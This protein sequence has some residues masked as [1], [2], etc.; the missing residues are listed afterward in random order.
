MKIILKLLI[1]L[2]LFTEIGVASEI[3]VFEFTEAELSQLEVRKVRGAD[4]KT[5]YSVGSNE[6]GNF[7]KSVADNSQLLK[8][9]QDARLPLLIAT[10]QIAG[11]I[12]PGKDGSF[13][14]IDNSGYVIPKP[15]MENLV[16]EFVDRARKAGIA[17]IGE[18][19]ITLDD[20]N[21]NFNKWNF[22]RF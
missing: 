19:A 4:N 6:N 14:E 13:Y 12:K 20:Y 18:R 21:Y 8:R 3:K 17:R 10:I 1:S 9:V 11:Q 2:F 16:I 15:E 22:W 5:N 7:L